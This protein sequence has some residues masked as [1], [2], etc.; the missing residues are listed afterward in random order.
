M[1]IVNGNSAICS[2]TKNI[3][4]V[5]F[6]PTDLNIILGF[7]ALCSC[8]QLARCKFLLLLN[9]LHRAEPGCPSDVYQLLTF[10]FSS[11]AIT[12]TSQLPSYYGRDQYKPAFWLILAAINNEGVMRK[13]LW[14]KPALETG[15]QVAG[16]LF[17]TDL[18]RW[19]DR[20]QKTRSG[21]TLSPVE[22]QIFSR[23][24]EKMQ[25][26]VHYFIF[27]DTLWDTSI[28]RGVKTHT[29]STEK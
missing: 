22:L 29:I 9:L 17:S 18:Q 15:V 24:V 27:T 25:E 21:R 12:A 14:P 28:H 23:P 2:W 4:F 8:W 5:L 6:I 1:W 26:S 16:Y 19:D 20:K 3:F 10:Y 11:T 13:H 7:S